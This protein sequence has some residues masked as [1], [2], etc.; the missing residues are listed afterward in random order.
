MK[1][2]K[3]IVSLLLVAFLPR[4]ASAVVVG[5]YTADTNT[6]FLFHFDE[7]AGSGVTTNVGLKGGNSYTVTNT[8]GSAVGLSPVPTV[9]T[10]LGVASYVGFGN[11]VST[12]TASIFT[13]GMVAYDQNRSGV[14]EGDVQGVAPSADIMQ[15]TNLNMG[16]GGQST[17][18][19]EAMIC[20]Y[21]TNRNQEI[22]C[23]DDYNGG[24]GFQFKITNLGQL[25]FNPIGGGTSAQVTVPI[26]T[27]AV[28][29][30]VFGAWYHVAA[31][32]DGTTVRLYWTKMGASV[33]QD[34]LI[35]SLTGVIGA[36]FGTNAAPLIIGGENRGALQESFIGKIDEVRISKVARSATEMMFAPATVV[37]NQQ[38]VGEEGVDYGSTGILS[39][40]AGSLTALSYQWWKDSAPLTGATNTTL[41]FTNATSANAGKYFCVITNL[42]GYASTSSVAS[43]VVGAANY[44]TNRYSFTSDASDSVGGQS[45]TL[46]G[47]YT[48][49][50]DGT[51]AL[52]GSSGYV[53]LPA[54][55][56]NTNVGAVT[57]E[58]WATFGTVANSSMLFAFG[59]TNAAGTSGL[60]YLFC[61]PHGSTARVA[62]TAGTSSGEQQAVAGT[63]LDNYLNVHIVA[64]FAPY[65]GY[66]ALYINGAL[67]AINTNVTVSLGSIV[68][69]C[70][71]IGRSLFSADPY[72]ACTL[73]EFRVYNG[74]LSPSTI[75]QSYLQ[76]PDNPLRSGAV[77]M[78]TSPTN[79]TVA[80][81][82][83]ASFSGLASG[84]PNIRYQ[85]YKNG[86]AVL[87]ATNATYSFTAATADNNATIYLV[88]SNTVS[89]V[90]Y[91]VTSSTVT[92]TVVAPETLVWL[93]VADN[94]WN[95]TS[96]NW[97]NS[98]QQV[99]TYGIYKGALFNDLASQTSIDVQEAEAPVSMTVSNNSLDYFFNSSAL[100]GSLNVGGTLLKT[101]TAKL[102]LD[103]TNTSAG[104]VLVQGGILQVGN[105]DAAG[106]LGTSVV[107][108]TATLSF[109]R[110][111][112]IAVPNTIH[113]SG[114]VSIDYG[115]VTLA[116]T[117]NDFTGPILVNSGILTLTNSGG[118]GSTVGGTTVGGSG[119]LLVAANQDFSAE[120]LTLNGS[121]Y[122]GNGAVHKSGAAGTASLAGPI[123]L[124]SDS[125]IFVDA[126]STLTLSNAITGSS[127]LT[128]GGAGALALN[129][130]SSYTGGTTFNLGVL[131]INTN[132]ALG[133]GLITANNTGRIVMAPGATLTNAL[134]AT[135]V[136]PSIANGLLMM[137]D[138]A[139][140]G[141]ATVSGP[142]EFDVNAAHGGHFYGPL[143]SGYLNI[144]GPIT[145]PASTFMII[146]DG[147]LRFS[148]G[149]SYPEMQIRAST[150]SL[151][152]NNGIATNAVV[153][154]AGN[155][156]A[157]LDLNG[158]S[159]SLAG[160]KDALT[161]ANLGI[162]TNSSSTPSTLRLDL[163]DVNSFNYG[164]NIMGN[165]GLTLASGHQ[166]LSVN[167]SSG[168]G[169]YT[170]TGNTL[171]SGGTLSIGNGIIISNTPSITIASGATLDTA[172]G[173]LSLLPNQTIQ[174][175][176]TVSGTVS[177]GGVAPAGVLTFN[178]DLGLTGVSSFRVNKT[179]GTNDQLVVSGTVTYGGT[180]YATNISGAL[181][182]GNTFTLVSAGASQGN[183]SQV[184]GRPGI[185]KV[186]AFT[187]GVL[188]VVA[189]STTPTNLTLKAAG[190][191]NVVVTWPADHTGWRLQSQTND[192]TKGL[193]TNW[194]DVPNS[195]NLNS[196]T[197]PIGATNGAV[198]YRMVN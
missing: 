53:Q 102:T 49:N 18:T 121:G 119:Q 145:M 74:T 173:G 124:A 12:N 111:D 87:N 127:A 133:T 108:N 81:G 34:N 70:S 141:V 114:V 183:F 13:N 166:T 150:T 97:S 30:Y 21:I 85:W 78:V 152:A 62:L 14:F 118:L 110:S 158:Y 120:P 151:G 170:Y 126:N 134:L 94:Y 177:G 167:S 98:A 194:V 148:G 142:L 169:L 26:P 15:M 73:N 113:G 96:Y 197:I 76:G 61:T 175:N 185:G 56:L 100:N 68:D 91:S 132:G 39:V 20:P 80:A 41:T 128:K 146:R 7:A 137:N 136:D 176:G 160:L 163:G 130:S 63:A 83:T 8:F 22:I 31:T 3:I 149:G 117:S 186:W 19:L 125:L 157:Y 35:A 154:L 181:S 24:R 69:N 182:I 51:V 84:T 116:S 1:Q 105:F 90:N 188:S 79:L 75:Q 59:N 115:N 164:G 99:V 168:I 38:P 195:T 106:S 190:K 172:A 58:T 28:N 48:V 189:M 40:G 159:Q 103:L 55:M 29:G 104:V 89:A 6:L 112:A 131:N 101:G 11:C 57:I 109:A 198:F 27:D 45:G 10:M 107:T 47:G 44:L 43:V 77:Q 72:L 92:L 46:T 93:G 144:S 88:A 165:V 123:T 161:P 155:G 5:P 16:N 60:N 17:W 129:H 64:V 52:D 66:E 42:A 23:T 138:N 174:G 191:G 95:S 156:T 82:L 36:N 140:G 184:A 135:A 2:I 9:T 178:G 162:V 147:R 32:Y 139:T 4:F 65:A 180:L 171:V 54:N 122:D 86:V 50:G 179:A 71:Y 187:N 192:V 67:A 153:D 196:M 193:G 143:S 37:I 33:I 25:N